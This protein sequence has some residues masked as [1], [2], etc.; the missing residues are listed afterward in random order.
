MALTL[1][2]A[3]T[4]VLAALLATCCAT[5]PDGPTEAEVAAADQW[6]AGDGKADAPAGY[7][8]LIGWAVDLYT[9]RMSAVWDNQE[10][11]ATAAGAKARVAALLAH[12]GITDPTQVR[13]PASVQRLRATLLDHSEVDVEIRGTYPR[14]L[15]LIG[16]PKGAGAYVDRAPFEDSLDPELCLTWTELNAAI[17]AAYMPGAYAVDF[18]CHTITERVLRALQVGSGDLAPQ[19]H[20]YRLAR[21]IW[22]PAGANPYP[23]DPTRWAV[24]RTCPP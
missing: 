4:L 10:H 24:S 20:T 11:P 17:D 14:V 5:T 23:T 6:A 19:I 13:F 2:S 16:D 18:V 1:P 7:D 22:G 15:R 9:N 3:G 8:G 12:N 21:W